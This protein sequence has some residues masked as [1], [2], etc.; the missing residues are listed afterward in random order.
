MQRKDSLPCGQETTIDL[1]PK[2]KNTRPK[3]P[4]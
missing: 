1:Q 2:Q 3:F 4:P